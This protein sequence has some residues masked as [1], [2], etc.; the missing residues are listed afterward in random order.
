MH[1]Q[2]EVVLDANKPAPVKALSERI[3]QPKGAAAK[4]KPATEKPV[5]NGGGRGGRTGRGRGAKRGRNAGRPKP[6]T[7]D[8]LDAEMM[9]YFD[10]NAANGTAP[11]ADAAAAP[12]AN[13][14]APTTGGDDLGM[15]EIS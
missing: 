10:A 6:K 3:G 7:A 12:T 8:E 14:A 2:I 1:Y 15:E 9:D 13:G 5:T 11:A 4:P